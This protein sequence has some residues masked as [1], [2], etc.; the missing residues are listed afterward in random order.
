MLKLLPPLGLD[1]PTMLPFPSKKYRPN[2]GVWPDRLPGLLPKPPGFV[3]PGVVEPVDAV[4]EEPVLAVEAVL[5]PV[6]A[7]PV[8]PEE[9]LPPVD[10]VVPVPVDAVVPVPL[11]PVVPVVP[12]VPLVPVP[13]V[14]PPAVL[15]PPVLPVVPVPPA[16][17][18]SVVSTVLRFKLEICALYVPVRFALV[19][20][21]MPYE[22]RG[23]PSPK[24]Q[25]IRPPITIVLCDGVIE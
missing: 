16:A 19:Q 1:I 23:R 4:L 8:M 15:V 3:E 14:V 6:V 9:L 18:F 7:V 10:P 12:L 13:L 11:V 17:L 22:T 5:E 24:P 20:P 2:P 21:V 25:K